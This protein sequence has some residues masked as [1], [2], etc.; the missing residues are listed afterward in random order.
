MCKGGKVKGESAGTVRIDYTPRCRAGDCAKISAMKR[1]FRA[2]GPVF[3]LIAA[4]LAAGAAGA[5]PQSFEIDPGHTFA[6]FEVRHLG[7]A[8]Q[9]GR[10]NHTSGR[11]II[12]PEAGSGSA[13]IRIDARSVST[14]NEDIDK[15]LRGA[16]YFAVVDFPT[17]TYKAT[18]IRFD[19]GKPVLI[20]GELSFLGV[21]RPLPLTVNGYACIGFPLPRCGADLS[22]RFRRSDFGLNAMANFV[23]DEVSMQ[24]QM[25]MVRP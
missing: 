17:I 2:A 1:L 7:I 9:R 24:I 19:A 13:D 4:L 11:V 5:A 18:A 15:L 22:A 23:G 10:F 21:T 6:Q 12:D 8:T 16:F 25:E 14:G 20:E 3:C